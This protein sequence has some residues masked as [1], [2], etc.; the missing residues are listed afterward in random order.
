MGGQTPGPICGAQL[1]DD[2]IDRGTMSRTQSRPPGLSPFTLT[3]PKAAPLVCERNA[4]ALPFPEQYFLQL[5]P[6]TDRWNSYVMPEAWTEAILRNLQKI[7]ASKAGTALLNSIQQA[8]TW[9]MVEPTKFGECNAHGF[10]APKRIINGRAFQGLVQMDPNSYLQGSACYKIKDRATNNRGFLP[11]EV[12]FHELIHAHRGSLRL[13]LTG[14]EPL[15]GGLIRYTREEEFLAVVI[16][17][18]YISDETNG[19]KSGLRRDHAGGYPLERELSTS[20]G[21]FQSSPQV[22]PLLKRFAEEQKALFLALAEV[23]ADFNPFHAMR[24]H[25][26]KV[27]ALS[28]SKLA[29]QREITVPKVPISHRTSPR[30]DV[31]GALSALAKE[32]LAPLLN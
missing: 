22:L 20:L 32:A 5:T 31:K 16:T 24:H 29:Q 2:W 3:P 26:A 11:D 1:G 8:A 9:I 25:A 28:K 10:A 7:A 18:I 30:P 21:F 6:P 12:L 27:E 14:G 17:N 13:A 15:G 19:V 23:K 4:A